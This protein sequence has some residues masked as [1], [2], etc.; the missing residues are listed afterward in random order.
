MILKHLHPMGWEAP[1]LSFRKQSPSSV[2]SFVRQVASASDGPFG[3]NS[4]DKKNCRR[5]DFDCLKKTRLRC[6]S[7]CSS[8]HKMF[9]RSWFKVFTL[10][11]NPLLLPTL[12]AWR[13]KYSAPETG[14][15][16]QI[17]WQWATNLCP[18]RSL[19]QHKGLVESAYPLVN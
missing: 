8:Q 7:L 5:E 12:C 4:T 3:G 10:C 2:V 9:V 19:T 14:E 16:Y 18:V 6:L 15:A 1:Q 17:W 11:R 13:L